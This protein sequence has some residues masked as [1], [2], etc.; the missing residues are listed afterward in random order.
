MESQKPNNDDTTLIEKTNLLLHNIL[1]LDP[2]EIKN[3]KEIKDSTTL[4]FLISNIINPNINNFLT[5]NNKIFLFN[6]VYTKENK[7]KLINKFNSLIYFCYRKNFSPLKSKFNFIIT[8]DSG[9]GCMIRCGQMIMARAIYKY[10]KSKNFTKEKSIKETIDYFLD[11][12]FNINTLPKKF[13]HII[14]KGENIEVFYPPFSIKIHCLLGKF[15]NKYAG[16]WFSDVNICQNY[17]DINKCLNVFEDMEIFN[18]ISDFTFSQILKQCFIE[19]KNQNEENIFNYENKNY[20]FKKMGLIFISMRLGI[21]NLNE[22]YYLSIK[23]LFKCKECLGLIGGETNLAHYFIGYN[24]KLNL[25][26]LDPHITKD[27]IN[28][29]NDDSIVENY[30]I[31]NIHEISMGNMSTGFSVGFLFRNLKEF[32]DMLL[33]IENYCKKR[34]HPCFGFIKEE[35]KLDVNCYENIFNDQDDF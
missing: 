27:A 21:S 25:L 28:I 8:G 2:D 18:F 34:A 32:K 1:T 24:D 33:F 4:N 14:N 15:Y 3:Y 16:E 5:N 23:E 35:V 9:W 30:L 11:L 17:S 20:I 6:K 7:Q 29:L 19:T 31:K 10:F 12:P 13:E 22:D 26:Y